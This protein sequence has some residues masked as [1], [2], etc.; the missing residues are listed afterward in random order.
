MGMGSK[1]DFL[2]CAPEV[3]IGKGKDKKKARGEKSQ[4]LVIH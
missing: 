2:T 4:C 1:G 3:Y